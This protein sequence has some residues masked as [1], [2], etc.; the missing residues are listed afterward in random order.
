LTPI[1]VLC[2][3]ENLCYDGTVW[4][5]ILDHSYA[6]KE[7][8]FHFSL[9]GKLYELVTMEETRISGFGNIRGKTSD[10]N[11]QI[12]GSGGG[13]SKGSSNR[14]IFFVHDTSA[15]SRP[16]P[17]HYQVHTQTH[18]TWQDSSGRGIGQNL[19]THNK[20]KRETPMPRRHSNPQSQQ[21]SG[22]RRTL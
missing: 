20:H 16:G 1:Y 15:T 5:R 9:F 10:N 18:H 8:K 14:K 4:V 19:T 2:I 13:S 22:R 12:G 17:P 11:I 7:R 21:A 3:M 6:S